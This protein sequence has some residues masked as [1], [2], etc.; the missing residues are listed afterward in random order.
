MMDRPF[1]GDHLQ[2]EDMEMGFKIIN[3]MKGRIK[4][5][6]INMYDTPPEIVENQRFCNFLFENCDFVFIILDSNK[7]DGLEIKTWT[8]FVLDQIAKHHKRAKLKRA[9]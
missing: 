9:E 5:V 3:P 1:S 6:S 8:L 7:I 2:T 4:P